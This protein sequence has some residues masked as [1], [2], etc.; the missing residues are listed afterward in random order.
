M[1]KGIS[2]KLPARRLLKKAAHVMEAIRIGQEMKENETICILTGGNDE[3]KRTAAGA[4]AYGFFHPDFENSKKET[5]AESSMDDEVNNTLA[6]FLAEFSVVDGSSEKGGD[7]DFWQE[8]LYDEHPHEKTM[9]ANDKSGTKTENEEIQLRLVE[10]V[11]ETQMGKNRISEASSQINGAKNICGFFVKGSITNDLENDMY[12]IILRLYQGKKA[13]DLLFL[14]LEGASEKFVRKLQFELDAIVAKVKNPD[15]DYYKEVLSY[16]LEESC[17]ELSD[18]NIKT[19]IVFLIKNYRADELQIEDFGKAIEKAKV[20]AEKEHRRK[21]ELKDFNLFGE[22]YYDPEQVLGNLVG[23]SKIK[24]KVERMK[25]LHAF[26]A[27][28]LGFSYRHYSYSLAFAGNPGTGKSEVAKQYAGILAKYGITNGK[29]ICAC[30][31]DYVGQYLG[32]TADLMRKL[33]EKS[34]GGVIFFD[35]AAAFLTDDVYA[36]EALTELVRFMELYPDVVC[37]FASYKNNIDKLLEK[38]AGLRSRISEILVFE[39]YSDD[40][41]YEILEYFCKKEQFELENSKDIFTE[42]VCEEKRKNPTDFGNARLSR[43]VFEKA[44]EI[45]ATET[46][47]QGKDPLTVHRI[48]RDNMAEAIRELRMN[49][50]VVTTKIKMGFE[51]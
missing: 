46:M 6:E 28:R 40:E 38:D 19:D 48:S 41:L 9:S 37:I 49:A 24:K 1:N 51:V 39:N 42:Y 35:E 4:I 34:R 21:L 12:E 3:S 22:T 36:G 27:R 10:Y 2:F 33:F 47:N 25:N 17:C 31:S 45:L 15:L 32:H 43:N 18:D 7:F 11:V 29:F 13:N 26:N 16:E 23:M 8:A 5:E 44:K 50:E 30:K 14:D 20:K